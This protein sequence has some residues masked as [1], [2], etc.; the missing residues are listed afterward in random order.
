MPYSLK[1]ISQPK[2]ESKEISVFLDKFIWY[3]RKKNILYY[4]NSNAIDVKLSPEVEKIFKTSIR[5][6]SK[7]QN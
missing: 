3:D 5:L 1:L 7:K 4:R 2:S 6:G